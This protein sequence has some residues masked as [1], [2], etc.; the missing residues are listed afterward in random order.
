[1]SD[2][3][4][5]LI[6]AYDLDGASIRLSVGEDIMVMMSRYMNGSSHSSGGEVDGMI[7]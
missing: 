7:K 3:Q 6:V 2:Y 1:M 5:T 4:P